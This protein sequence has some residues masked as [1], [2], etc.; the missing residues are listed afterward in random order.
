[1]SLFSGQPAAGTVRA[2]QE[3]V[4]AVLTERDLERTAAVFPQIYRNLGAILSERLARTNRLS[5]R[6]AP[7]RVVVL[8]DAAAS[9]PV[10]Y[11]LACSVAWHTRRPALLAVVGEALPEPLAELAAGLELPLPRRDGTRTGADVM[12]VERKNLA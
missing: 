4:V 2:T 9:H 7:G 12:L 5:V 10:G 1:V 6:H 11:A 8:D 3:L